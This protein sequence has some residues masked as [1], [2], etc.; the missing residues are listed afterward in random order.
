[1]SPKS[2]PMLAAV[3]LHAHRTVSKVWWRF[4]NLAHTFDLLKYL[5]SAT[6]SCEFAAKGRSK[7]IETSKA[8]SL[9]WPIRV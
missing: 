6:I 5:S 9:Q 7:P 4:N 1:M 8:C 2:R 3:N